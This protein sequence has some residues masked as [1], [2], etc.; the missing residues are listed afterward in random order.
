MAATNSK[1]NTQ[2]KAMSEVL[3]QKLGNTWYIFSEIS[4]EIVYS[5]LPQGMDPKT[6]KLELYEVIENHMKKVASNKIRTPDMAA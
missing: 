6:T 4:G 1:I 2:E 3:F 5:A